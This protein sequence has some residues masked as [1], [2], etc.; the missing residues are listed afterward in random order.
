MGR[1]SPEKAA[2][3]LMESPIKLHRVR[4]SLSLQ[5]DARVGPSA[6]H[7]PHPGR[8]TGDVGLDF[9]VDGLLGGLDIHVDGRLDAH[10]TL[11]FAE[12]THRATH[13]LL[14]S[15]VALHLGRFC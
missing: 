1:E 2:T 9:L 10:G 4:R 8:R 13:P 7:D 6:V 12:R 5:S 11:R 3:L 15:K 14:A